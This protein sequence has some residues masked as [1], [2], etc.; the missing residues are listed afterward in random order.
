MI[1]ILR[2]EEQTAHAMLRREQIT[3]DDLPLIRR[4]QLKDWNGVPVR[5]DG[6]VK[7]GHWVINPD[8]SIVFIG[9]GGGSFEI[10]G[11]FD[12]YYRQYRIRIECGGGGARG[13]IF[14]QRADGGYDIDI[15]VTFMHLPADL[16]EQ[17]DTMQALV[18]EAFAADHARPG[19]PPAL[20]V[21]FTVP[22]A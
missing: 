7:H 14:G 15:F 11:T 3:A 10:P 13:R 19:A 18:V 17:R 5:E 12:L 20:T 22:G 6:L 4:L 8:R 1:K 2:F 16:S 9:A 21:H